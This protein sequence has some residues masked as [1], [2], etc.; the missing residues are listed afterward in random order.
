[1]IFFVGMPFDICVYRIF[2]IRFDD[3]FRTPVISPV[4]IHLYVLVALYIGDLIRYH[5]DIVA[6]D[7]TIV[8]IHNDMISLCG[9]SSVY[10]RHSS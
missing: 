1:M 10:E 9:Y 7:C 3:D 2:I 8:S 4:C 5:N 6:Y